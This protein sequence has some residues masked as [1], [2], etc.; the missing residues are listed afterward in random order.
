VAPRR[1]RVRIARSGETHKHFLARRIEVLVRK[2]AL[3]KI[4]KQNP[5]EE[6]HRRGGGGKFSPTDEK[7]TISKYEKNT[8][9]SSSITLKE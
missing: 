8:K 6:Q 9:L 3:S 5:K 2:V 1:T 4:V 7:F